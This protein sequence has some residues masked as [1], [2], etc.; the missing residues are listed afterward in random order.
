MLLLAKAR[1]LFRSPSPAMAPND[2]CSEQVL[3][4]GA[5]LNVV[6]DST[7][8]SGETAAQR[9]IV[10]IE[11]LSLY[12]LGKLE[13]I[14]EIEAEN[15]LLLDALLEISEEIHDA[16]RPDGIV[17]KLLNIATIADGALLELQ[18]KRVALNKEN[19]A[20]AA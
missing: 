6:D 9:A 5:F 17:A 2:S 7:A 12:T 14:R 15:G 18:V 19:E 8:F 1:G 3:L 20:L 16:R 13:K 11:E 10:L 4:L